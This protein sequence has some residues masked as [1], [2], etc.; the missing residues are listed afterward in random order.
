MGTLSAKGGRLSKVHT[1]VCLVP[2]DLDRM[3][4]LTMSNGIH[5]NRVHYFLIYAYILERYQKV[6]HLESKSLKPRFIPKKIHIGNL[7][8]YSNIIFVLRVTQCC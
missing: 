7:P 1:W 6:I 3:I 5:L 8:L 4:I 2:D